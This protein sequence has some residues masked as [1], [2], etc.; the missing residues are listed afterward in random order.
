[1]S[2][3]TG[4]IVSEMS[5]GRP[6][7]VDANGLEMLDALAAAQPREDVVFFGLT[8]GRNQHPDRRPIELVG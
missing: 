2:S 4:E 3:R 5:S 1:M 7:L 8:I 6:S